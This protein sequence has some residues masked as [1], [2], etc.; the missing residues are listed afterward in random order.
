MVNLLFL[1]NYS[2]N[3]QNSKINAADV[4]LIL[5][6][7][8]QVWKTHSPQFIRNRRLFCML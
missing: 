8:R 7:S 1:I 4:D 6:E 3:G 5:V 2:T